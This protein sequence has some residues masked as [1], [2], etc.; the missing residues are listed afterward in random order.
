MVGGGGDNVEG[1]FL[2]I[3]V[4][5]LSHCQRVN[6]SPLPSEGKAT[7]AHGRVEHTAHCRCCRLSL[8]LL[9]M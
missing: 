1:V 2:G 4:L 8:F 5:L 7:E 3:P 9:V 6:A